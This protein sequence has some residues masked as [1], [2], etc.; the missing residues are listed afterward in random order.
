MF[1]MLTNQIYCSNT[2]CLLQPIPPSSA[3]WEDL[4]LD[5]IT[6]LPS[7]SGFNVILIVVDLFTK[8][9]HFG[10]FP[11]HFTASKVAQHFLDMVCKLHGFPKSLISNRDPIFI[12]HFLQ[13]L[14][15]LNGTKLQMSIAY[16]PQ[17]DGQTKVLNRI[18]KQY[19]HTFVH[20]NPSQWTKFLSLAEWCY[21]TATH[22][23]IGISPY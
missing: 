1:Y 20:N 18:L 16:H 8:R 2:P 19:L 12:N 11:A 13:H 22:S 7:S 23:T 14:F 4:D 10:T 5:F 6:D 17:S 9:A 3:P 15:R 21:N